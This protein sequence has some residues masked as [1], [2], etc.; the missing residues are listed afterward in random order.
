M[1]NK[2]QENITNQTIEIP[3]QQERPRVEFIQPT[4]I[5]LGYSFNKEMGI[6]VFAT[7]DIEPGELIERCYAVQLANRSRYQHDPQI[8]R[9]LY[10]NRCECQ[11]CVIHGSHMN[12]VLGYGMIYNHQDEPNTEWNFKWDKDYADVI[13]IKPIKAGEEIYVSYGSSYFKE[14]EYFS[15][16]GEEFKEI[17]ENLIEN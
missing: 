12:M 10:T 4:K 14:R 13:C 8:K 16:K 1:E 5:K 15:A 11:Q 2:Q 3:I 17:Q 6:G 9:Y 7:K